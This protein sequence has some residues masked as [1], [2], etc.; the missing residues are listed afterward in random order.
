[1]KSFL[2]AGG[3]PA[4]AF[5]GGRAF[6]E[7]FIDERVLPIKVLIVYFATDPDKIVQ[8]WDQDQALFAKFLRP[9]DYQLMIATE[10]DFLQQ[11]GEVDTLYFKGGYTERLIEALSKQ[12]DWANH[13][14]GKT[15]VGTSA[16]AEMLSRYYFDL[17]QMTIRLGF[18]ILPI[19][20]LVHYRSQYNNQPFDWNSIEQD[21]L[22]YQ[23]SLP[24]HR[25][26]DGTF[27]R[28][29]VE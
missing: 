25:L 28:V 8:K 27:E 18:N 10:Q 17:D 12:P 6:I 3:Y 4:K 11:I 15:I 7:A 1:M 24:L 9:S 5:D 20:V 2:L 29:V 14:A 26:A 22:A 13:I 19:K 21:L 23:E 16:G